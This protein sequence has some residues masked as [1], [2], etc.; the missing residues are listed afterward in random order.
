VGLLDLAV[1]ET[2]GTTHGDTGAVAYYYASGWNIY[3]LAVA[4]TDIGRFGSGCSSCGRWISQNLGEGT[5]VPSAAVAVTTVGSTVLAEADGDVYGG[6]RS[7]RALVSNGNA[8]WDDTTTLS[9]G[10]SPDEVRAVSD[11]ERTLVSWVDHTPD[12]DVLDL[13]GLWT[14]DTLSADPDTTYLGATTGDAGLALASSRDVDI[15]WTDD[16]TRPATLRAFRN[17]ATAMVAPEQAYW[18]SQDVSVQWS[19]DRIRSAGA[20]YDVRTRRATAVHGFGAHDRWHTDI[21]ATSA[22]YHAASGGTYCF[23][24]RRRDPAGHLSSWSGE[25]CT[26]VAFDDVRLSGHGWTRQQSPQSYHR[27]RLRAT[28]KGS[29]L[30]INNVRARS[31]ALLVTKR[32][33]SGTVHVQFGSKDLG[34]FNTRGHRT[35][36]AVIPVATFRSAQTGTLTLTVASTGAPVYIDG[37]FLNAG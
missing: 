36:K 18:R 5:A 10:G 27:S 26:A 33:V 20:R 31:L 28:V 6:V 35:F 3:N 8:S 30:S 37:I 29:R 1:R 2:P 34:T 4:R 23:S 16:T 24:T 12:G 32:H 11:G 15:V 17:A 22:S 14:S 9:K 19:G 7:L 25:G 13:R 21:A